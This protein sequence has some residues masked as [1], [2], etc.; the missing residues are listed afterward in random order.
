MSYIVIIILCIAQFS[1]V[2]HSMNRVI[3]VYIGILVLEII[4]CSSLK[5]SF[6]FEFGETSPNGGRHARDV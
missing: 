5:Y 2:E 1:T 6:A 3:L 4:L